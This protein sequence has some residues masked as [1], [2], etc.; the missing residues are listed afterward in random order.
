MRRTPTYLA[1]VPFALF[2]F[3]AAPTANP[4]VAFEITTTDFTSSPAAVDVSRIEIEGPNV[5]MGVAGADGEGRMIFRGEEGE[6]IVVDDT[7]RSY[8]QLDSATL[9]GLASQVNAAMAQMEQMLAQ[10]PEDQRALVEQMRA[11]GMGGMPGMDAMPAAAPEIEIN[12]T[13]R[14]DTKAGFAAEEWEVLEDGTVAR[15][16]WVAPWSE[17]DGGEEAR[18]A[19]AGMIA[20]FDDFL[21]AMPTMPGQDEPMIRNPFRN[22]DMANGM[23]VFTQELGADGSVES[24]TVV[25]GVERVTFGP[26]RFEP[27]QGYEARELPGGG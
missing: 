27:P 13:G 1:A 11:R 17:I 6:M 18:A 21:A 14:S 26:E 23:P 16:L 24:E 15:R 10:L 12:N 2:A 20:F 4:G 9:A 7:D 22:F 19:M 5:A 3:V 25:T 8:F